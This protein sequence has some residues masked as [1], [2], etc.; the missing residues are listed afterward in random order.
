MPASWASFQGQDNSS[1]PLSLLLAALLGSLLPL[2]FSATAALPAKLAEHY[3]STAVLSLP[4]RAGLVI[5]FLLALLA[6]LFR[7]AR[8]GIKATQPLRSTPP[9]SFCRAASDNDHGCP[10]ALPALHIGASRLDASSSTFAP[11][12]STGAPAA[13]KHSLQLRRRGAAGAQLQIVAS[14]EALGGDAQA[15]QQALQA[16][17]PRTPLPAPSPSPSLV[18]RSGA[19]G[20][21]LMAT[22]MATSPTG[23]GAHSKVIN[24]AGVPVADFYEHE[25][26]SSL[27]LWLKPSGTIARN[28]GCVP[29]VFSATNFALAKSAATK[30][31][32]YLG[33]TIVVDG[34]SRLITAY[35][36]DVNGDGDVLDAGEAEVYLDQPLDSQVV[37]GRTSYKV[38]EGF[39]V[40]APAEAARVTKLAGQGN[41]VVQWASAARTV[42]LAGE[43][44]S[45]ADAADRVLLGP[46]ALDIDGFY[47]GMTMF[48]GSEP[49]AITHYNGH[50]RVATVSPPFSKQPSRGATFR[51]VRVNAARIATVPNLEGPV[52]AVSP[53]S[54]TMRFQIHAPVQEPAALPV[55]LTGHEITVT[56]GSSV[57]HSVILAHTTDGFVSVTAMATPA[58]NVSTFVVHGARPTMMAGSRSGL[59]GYGAV[60]LDGKSS[61]FTFDSAVAPTHRKRSAALSDTNST[62]SFA[63]RNCSASRLECVISE[64]LLETGSDAL[65]AGQEAAGLGKWSMTFLSVVRPAERNDLTGVVAPHYSASGTLAAPDDVSAIYQSGALWVR[66][67]S[68]AGAVEDLYTGARIRLMLLDGSKVDRVVVGYSL[69]RR[70]LLDQPVPL[71]MV[72]SKTR[73]FITHVE[74]TV[75]AV[76]LNSEVP[77]RAGELVGM[78]ISLADEWRTITHHGARAFS[79]DDNGRVVTLSSPLLNAPVP[80][81]TR[82]RLVSSHRI[83]SLDSA[84]AHIDVGIGRVHGEETGEPPLVYQS[85]VQDGQLHA[86]SVLTS[87]SGYVCGGVFDLEI[88]GSM[89]HLGSFA[90]AEHGAISKISML[91]NAPTVYPGEQA[92]EGGLRYPSNCNG[93]TKDTS[94]CAR[95]SQHSSISALEI[96]ASGSGYV[97][98]DIRATSGST[99]EGFVASFSVDEAGGMTD[100]ELPNAAA[101][102]SGYDAHTEVELYYPGTDIKMTGSVT[103]VEVIEGG[104]GHKVGPLVVT[105]QGSCAGAGLAG[106]CH[107]DAIGAVTHIVLTAH[108]E[109][110]SREDAPV[111]SCGYASSAPMMIANVASGAGFHAVV[112]SGVVL[113]AQQTRQETSSTVSA[114]V[115]GLFAG[116]GFTTGCS[117]GDEMLG[118]GGGGRGFVAHVTEVSMTGEIIKLDVI[119]SGS[120]YTS[121]PRVVA[122]NKAC[123][124]D[125]PASGAG[126]GTRS[127]NMDQCW[128]AE[129]SQVVPVS[130]GWQIQAVVIDG[131]RGA[132]HHY[133]GGLQARRRMS[134]V[135]IGQA[136]NAGV[137]LATLGARRATKAGGELQRASQLWA[138]EVAEV[139]VYQCSAGSG[140]GGERLGCTSPADLDRLGRYLANKFQL[141]WEAAAGLTG[142]LGGATA[143]PDHAL[144]VVQGKAGAGS[145]PLLR[146]VHPRVGMGTSAQTITVSGRYFGGPG[147]E[148]AVEVRLGDQRCLQLKLMTESAQGTANLSSATA[149]RESIAVC[150]VPRGISAVSDVTVVA[151]GVSGVLPNA[152]RHGAP[153]I[154][155]LVPAKV[156]SGGGSV[157]TIMG[158]NMDS[159]LPFSVKLESH[160]TT[161]CSKV[162]VVSEGELRCHLPKLLRQ[163]TKVVIVVNDQGEEPVASSAELQVTKVP[164]FYTECPLQPE[165]SRCMTCCLRSCQRWELSPEGNNR[166]LGGAY[167]DHCSDECSMYVCPSAAAAQRG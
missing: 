112:A 111:L 128:S 28:S 50:A 130:E 114:R 91:K 99:G 14:A 120:G 115:S 152:F 136:A 167:Y 141:S 164:P 23:A 131:E 11:P 24:S 147:D 10:A 12:P 133:V 129:I 154:H 121:A 6:L 37:A 86:V 100:Y 16:P 36:G 80:G 125:V 92:L 148:D 165:G 42:V 94:G 64:K 135:N 83:L 30:P 17:S 105:C 95:K 87:G 39:S 132:M 60:A 54:P 21:A 41:D 116:Q 150:T 71:E 45:T 2:L 98:G 13:P 159:A 69:D 119:N 7:R 161:T 140:A 78:H 97:P 75:S 104:S 124:C 40:A 84:K 47:A 96:T 126:Q 33:L 73:F 18:R 55:D 57:E 49:R 166:A 89:W 4:C 51:V 90:C 25:H 43:V 3:A 67:G 134:T 163:N 19:L 144:A 66:L 76:T 158:T 155:S 118:I 156:N 151:W 9:T 5:Y 38:F 59:Q 103:T 65:A 31:S 82:F 157:L 32:A 108:G 101:H 162:E 52:L 22:M 93:K 34:Q 153:Q 61:F 68:A 137:D 145:V 48:I 149:S 53:I 113:A 139:L 1:W 160:V 107:V 35:T 20:A 44:W 56:T 109:G 138:G 127:G 26:E 70:A 123:R 46:A 63:S 15:L 74:N 143:G 72:P 122:K 77:V 110:Y 117:V 62:T 29:R 27:R 81:S 102:G 146:S 142:G 58:S 88:G 8:P 79:S 85:S 106:V